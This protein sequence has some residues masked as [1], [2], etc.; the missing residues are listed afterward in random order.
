MPYTW[1]AGANRRAAA[2]TGCR[3]KG[4]RQAGTWESALGMAIEAT[5]ALG[6]SLVLAWRWKMLGRWQ[7][8]AGPSAAANGRAAHGTLPHW[9][10]PLRP[11]SLASRQSFLPGGPPNKDSPDAWLPASHGIR[12]HRA[13]LEPNAGPAVNDGSALACARAQP[14]ARLLQDPL[15]KARASPQADCHG[16]CDDRLAKV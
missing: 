8:G 13:A 12:R 5:R 4:R 6:D 10:A 9:L 1:T 14:D 2:Q 7:V 11:A 16:P 15:G 3:P